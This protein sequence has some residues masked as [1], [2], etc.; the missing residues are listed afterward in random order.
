MCDICPR[1][2]VMV[3]AI[4]DVANVANHAKG[5]SLLG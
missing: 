1:I 5:T 2:F 3:A 4:G